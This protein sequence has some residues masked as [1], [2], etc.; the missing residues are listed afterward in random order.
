MICKF[1]YH[2]KFKIMKNF[3]GTPKKATH[4]DHLKV[5][6]LAILIAASTSISTQ[7]KCPAPLA[8]Q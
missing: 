8:Y 2:A 5:H 6:F 7:Q 3:A 4:K 1:A